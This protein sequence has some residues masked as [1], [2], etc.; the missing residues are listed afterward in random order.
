[1]LTKN[2][3]AKKY[4]LKLLL[5]AYMKMGVSDFGNCA[6]E[7]DLCFCHLLC[8]G[9]EGV[10]SKGRGEVL[11]E[12]SLF[13]CT[14]LLERVPDLYS[15]YLKAPPKF[16]KV[17]RFPNVPPY[18]FSQYF[19]KRREQPPKNGPPSYG[20]RSV[21]PFMLFRTITCS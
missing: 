19:D 13:I 6:C 4:I 12:V 5:E 9:G 15:S 1:M 17:K 11:R 7:W 8:G 16:K 21:T 18:V 2:F 10:H 14:F 3:D 20:P